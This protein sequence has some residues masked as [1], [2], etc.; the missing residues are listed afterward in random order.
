M[1]LARAIFRA[2]MRGSTAIKRSGMDLQLVPAVSPDEW[3]A[4]RTITEVERDAQRVE[5][6]PW[7]KAEDTSTPG[8]LSGDEVAAI[9]RR[10]FREPVD[11][12]AADAGLDEGLEALRALHDLL[13]SH[14]CASYC[15]TEGIKISAMATFLGSNESGAHV[16]AYRL[17]VKN[18]RP[19]AV[20]LKA[21]HW[22]ICDADGQE[23]IVVPRG[24]P[25]VVGQTP[26]LE[27]GAEFEYASGTELKAPRGAV[28]GAFEFASLEEGG[29]F[30][31]E[32][33]PFA[34]IAPSPP[35]S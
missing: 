16:F 9:A 6:F 29:T 30:E 24:S 3:G 27:T 21:R 13:A 5:L 7:A 22:V 8:A 25:G 14:A 28:R 32:V 23:T 2:A 19:D 10:R 11:D 4:H 31:A 26:T 34:L 33:N 12:A 15:E 20:M 17:R 18:T 35:S 1:A